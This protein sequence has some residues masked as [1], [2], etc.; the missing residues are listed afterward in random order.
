VNFDAYITGFVCWQQEKVLQNDWQC[1]YFKCVLLN[2]VMFSFE[3]EICTPFN[4]KAN[5]Y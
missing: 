4:K 5:I 3:V 2:D 1:L